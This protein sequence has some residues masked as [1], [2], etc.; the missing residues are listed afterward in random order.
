MFFSTG[1]LASAVALSFALLVGVVVGV[2][3][4]RRRGARQGATALGSLDSIEAAL[5]TL[6]ADLAT[7]RQQ[8]DAAREQRDNEARK[9]REYFERIDGIVTEA[10]ECRRLLVRTGA[11]HAAAQAMMIVEIES[12]TGQY[13]LLARQYRQATGKPP[14]RPEPKLNTAIQVVANEFRDAHVTPYQQTPSPGTVQGS[15]LSEG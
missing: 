3:L 12:L 2:L 9:A 1:P 4:Q 13:Q 15:P 8:T 5:R 6:E 11:E 14:P 7:Q 10:N